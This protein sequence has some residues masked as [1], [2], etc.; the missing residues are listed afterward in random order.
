MSTERPTRIKICGIT[1]IED[2]EHAVRA[3]ADFLGLNFWPGSRRH[4][5]IEL[6]A[7]L[8]AAAREVHASVEI[9]GLFV[10][11]TAA[12][13]HDVRQHVDLDIVQL[14]GDEPDELITELGGGLEVWKAFAVHGPA[15]LGLIRSSP[16]TAQVLDAPSA[17]RGGSGTTF[18]WAIAATAVGDGRRVV[19]AGGLTPDNVAAA[20][21]QVQPYAV[22]VA[23]GVERA[24][25]IKDPARVSAFIAAA[26]GAAR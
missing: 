26:R 4:V 15:S 11:P 5:S 1:R 12:E 8:A 21:A 22:D 7:A 10:N 25:G 9:V 13:V 3:G 6:G 2:A 18:D 20:I 16:S 24:P 19:L 17:G 23:S 14:H